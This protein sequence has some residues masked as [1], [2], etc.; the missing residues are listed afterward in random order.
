L[1]GPTD[2]NLFLAVLISAAT[3]FG[4]IWYLWANREVCKRPALY[5]FA[6]G[7]LL[8]AVA[9]YAEPSENV[10]NPFGYSGRYFYIPTVLMLWTFILA[11][12]SSS[13]WRLTFP[14]AGVLLAVL[15]VLNIKP[16][17]GHFRDVG[18]QGTAECLRTQQ[19]CLTQMNPP[20]PDRWLPTDYQLQHAGAAEIKTLAASGIQAFHKENIAKRK[21]APR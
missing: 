4:I 10:L 3:T 5:F 12:Q 16:Y 21:T 1:T 15:F 2:P 9:C 11:E 7:L 14:I 6:Y 19:T 18:W 8:L 13:R 17:G 20:L